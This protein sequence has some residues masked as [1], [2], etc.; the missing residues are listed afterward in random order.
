MGQSPIK[1]DM[2]EYKLS[3]MIRT[4]KLLFSVLLQLELD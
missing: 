2:K 4:L 1:I 3:K